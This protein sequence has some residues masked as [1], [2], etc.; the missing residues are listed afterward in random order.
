MRIDFT[1]N[2][3]VRLRTLARRHPQVVQLLQASP[4]QIDA[5][6][7]ANVGTLADVKGALKIILKLLVYIARKEYL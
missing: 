2:D 6:V 5:W 1:P 7:D 4:E 3:K